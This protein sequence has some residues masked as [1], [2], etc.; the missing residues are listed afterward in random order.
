M[1]PEIDF[2]FIRKEII[3]SDFFF[4]TPFGERLLTYADYIA[5][6]R[7][8]KFIEKFL[9]HIQRSYANTH[10]EDDVTGRTMTGL[11]HSAE[12]MI[13][14]SFNAEKNCYVIATGTG[15]TGAIAK[16]QEIL[17]V[18]IPSASKHRLK[19]LVNQSLANDSNK[20]TIYNSIRSDVEKFKP[21]IFVGPYEHHS[22]DIMWRESLGEVI[23]IDLTAEGFID[24][25]DLEKKV[26]NPNFEKRFKIGSFSA[27]SNVSGVITPIYDVARILH[28]Y[29]AL[30][31]VDFAASAP[32]VE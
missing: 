25:T 23:E 15:A 7:T 24:L 14:K 9:L 26:S 18:Y 3:G 19:D 4:E 8:L 12:E 22:N 13:K 17:G 32:Y 28:K 1:N 5:S 10:T 21:V 20:Q 11:L 31:L 30:A 16:L 27:A 29:G 2:D 6:G